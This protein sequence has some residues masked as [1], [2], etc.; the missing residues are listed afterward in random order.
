MSSWK[1]ASGRMSSQ[2]MP[3]QKI[4]LHKRFKKYPHSSPVL[5]SHVRVCHAAGRHSAGE[6]TRQEFVMTCF[7]LSCT[8]LTC[9]PMCANNIGAN[10]VFCVVANTHACIRCVLKL[11]GR[12]FPVAPYYVTKRQGVVKMRQGKPRGSLACVRT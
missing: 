7:R 8:I 12:A 6:K 3:L 1:T 9:G 4:L 10:C 5:T 2:F 11:H